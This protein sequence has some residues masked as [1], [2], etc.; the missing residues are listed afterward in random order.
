MT[1]Y[2]EGDGLPK[3]SPWMSGMLATAMSSEM[4]LMALR[5]YHDGQSNLSVSYS[6]SRSQAPEEDYTC[7]KCR[8]HHPT[9][10]NV[11]L[12]GFGEDVQAGH[13]SIKNPL[14]LMEW[15]R[16]LVQVGLCHTCW[17]EEG[18]PYN[19]LAKVDAHH[20]QQVVRLLEIP[21]LDVIT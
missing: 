16:L 2:R 14:D 9:G 18:Y 4:G 19:P 5:S 12:F 17:A 8:E 10:L 20:V 6:F 7:D 21:P 1:E 15:S 13:D 11:A 3:P